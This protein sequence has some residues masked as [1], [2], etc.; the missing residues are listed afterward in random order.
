[1]IA[2]AQGYN[3]TEYISQA[4]MIAFKVTLEQKVLDLSLREVVIHTNL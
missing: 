1:M 2:N 4:S 3:N